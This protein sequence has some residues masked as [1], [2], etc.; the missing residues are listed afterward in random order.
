VKEVDALMAR[1][2]AELEGLRE[3]LAGRE[4]YVARLTARD[5][6]TAE[7]NRGLRG[8]AMPEVDDFLDEAA[9]ELAR[10]QG[11]IARWPGR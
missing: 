10:L 5:V 6:E 2:A 8:Y 7:F 11:M 1:L 3:A 4:G 9:E